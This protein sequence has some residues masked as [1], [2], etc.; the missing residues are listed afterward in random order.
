MKKIEKQPPTDSKTVPTQSQTIAAN[1][2]E[3]LLAALEIP[4]ENVRPTVD[5]LMES[6][7]VSNELLSMRLG[8]LAADDL[9]TNQVS[10]PKH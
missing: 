6:E 9:R 8:K 7:S 3:R 4:R 1:E 2:K 5:R 10:R